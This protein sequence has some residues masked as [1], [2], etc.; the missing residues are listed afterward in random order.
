MNIDKIVL[1][2][3]KYIFAIIFLLITLIIFW[4]SHF[5]RQ[6]IFICEG[7]EKKLETHEDINKEKSIDRY[8][9]QKYL[10][11]NEFY[12]GLIYRLDKFSKE[13]CRI[14]NGQVVLCGEGK[15][16]TP[17][18]RDSTFDLVEGTLSYEWTWVDS[19]KTE[20][21]IG[22]NFKCKK[23]LRAIDQ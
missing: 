12:W 18:Y 13:Q 1:R 11:V 9:F 21:Y 20:K 10:I 7:V 2:K 23:T 15:Y 14:I 16:D 6:H 17:E 3:L 5:P 19:K 4:A 8:P 22:S